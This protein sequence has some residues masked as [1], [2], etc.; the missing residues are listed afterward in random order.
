MAKLLITTK[1][2][3]VYD[4]TEKSI[5]VTNVPGVLWETLADLNGALNNQLKLTPARGWVFSKKRLET[6]VNL[7]NT[8]ELPTSLSPA[9]NIVIAL[10]PAP[11]PQ[12]KK[13]T[14]GETKKTPPTDN[15]P[16]PIANLTIIR[17][18]DHLMKRFDEDSQYSGYSIWDAIKETKTRLIN[19]V[20][21]NPPK[22]VEKIG[23]GDDEEDS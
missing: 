22:P 13:K 23:G 15:Q 3:T 10:P 20:S 14:D 6:I 8:Y 1:N 9:T 7:L 19:R 5:A 17:E 16:Q 4:Y 2:G 21:G 12:I 11:E 18:F